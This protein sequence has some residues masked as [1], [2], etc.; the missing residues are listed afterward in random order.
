M[1]QCS[2]SSNLNLF[3]ILN[4]LSLWLHVIKAQCYWTK[5]NENYGTETIEVSGDRIV[6]IY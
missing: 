2:N 1:I 5:D 6:Y 4:V 3:C